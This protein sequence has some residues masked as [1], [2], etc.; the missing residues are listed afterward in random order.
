MALKISVEK[1]LPV[2][3]STGVSVTPLADNKIT[4][5][6]I[7]QIL[8]FG[9]VEAQT[10]DKV[11]L[12]TE[13]PAIYDAFVQANKDEVTKL[14]KE[15]RDAHT[16]VHA[17]RDQVR[18]DRTQVDT[19]QKQVTADKNTVAADKATV[20]TD[21]KQVQDWR[22]HV[23][24]WTVENRNID[25]DV[26]TR[27]SDVA[28]KHNNVVS[29][30]T[31]VVNKH[32]DV[33]TK[34]SD[35]S[36]KYPDVVT[37]HSDVVTKH[38]QVDT[39]QKQVTTDKNTVASDKTTVN[40]YK[41][42]S[43]DYAAQ[44]LSS[45]NSAASS[46]STATTKATEATTQANRA[47]TEA[48]RAKSIADGIN[49]NGGQ[50]TGNLVVTGTIKEGGKLLSDKYAQITYVDKQ[51][52]DLK[53]GADGAYDTLKELQDAIQ[54][55]EGGI[56]T[57]TTALGTKFDKT[58]GNISGGI[59]ASGV[60][61]GSL[62]HAKGYLTIQPYGSTYGDGNNR[63][64]IYYKEHN[65]GKPDDIARG[66]VI[67]ADNVEGGNEPMDIWLSGHRV[68]HNGNRPTWDHIG[69]NAVI[70]ITGTYNKLQRGYLCAHSDATGFIPD[71]ASTTGRSRV[72]TS[73]WWFK[74]SYVAKT[75]TQELNVGDATTNITIKKVGNKLQFLV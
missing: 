40:N 30:H 1:I 15:V 10:N 49:I 54:N 37:K 42:E 29:K 34:H 14:T 6:N 43:K 7:E 46:A 22:S 71:A 21:K 52:A 8:P 38:G 61:S 70:N 45:K 62:T 59:A 72:G 47:K 11:I 16:H 64:R 24:Q 67:S 57:I 73:S 20:A 66:L 39:W 19:W 56:G 12:I 33:V 9:Q 5:V 25:E 18:A 50:V 69:G 28:T 55:N 13:T 75:F 58:G 32:S 4:K 23:S 17:D 3:G 27:Q 31:D 44:A 36:T 48:D 35:I 2:G 68:Y 65:N 51:I 26:R 41:N 63:C 60:I 53:G 74:E